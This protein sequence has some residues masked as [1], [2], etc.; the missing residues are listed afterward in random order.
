MEDKVPLQIQLCVQFYIN[1]ETINIGLMAKYID[2]QIRSNKM[3]DH[4]VTVT[5]KVTSDWT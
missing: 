4:R 2:L 1:N 5:Q 3:E